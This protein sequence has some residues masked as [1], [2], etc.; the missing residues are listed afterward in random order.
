M[1]KIAILQSNYIPWKGYFDMIAAVDEFILYDD[2]QFTKNDWRNRNKIK[3]QNGVQWLSI[4]VGQNISRLIREVELKDTRWQAKHWS[5]ICQNYKRSSHFD[6]VAEKLEPLYLQ[7]EYTHLSILNRTLIEFVCGQLGIKTK[8]SN[9]WDYE[10]FGGQTER[11][12][13]MCRKA[14]ASEYISGPSAKSYLHESAFTDCNIK[15]TWFDYSGYP[16]YPQLWGTFEHGVSII[17][18]L[19]NCGGDAPGYMKYVHSGDKKSV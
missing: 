6:D 13:N 14:G 7:H 4:P 15:V 9:S 17:D 2:V 10:V 18:L 1:K 19:F 16:N 12:V 8:I 5:T 11:L 3:T